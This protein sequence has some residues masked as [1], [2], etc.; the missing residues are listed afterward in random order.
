MSEENGWIEVK[1]MKKVRRQERRDAQNQEKQKWED[2]QR[3]VRWIVTPARALRLR[4]ALNIENLDVKLT[5]GEWIEYQRKGWV[6]TKAVKPDEADKIPQSDEYTEYSTLPVENDY[7]DV[8]LF[9]RQLKP[10][11]VVEG[12]E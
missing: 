7:N 10:R 1:N 6:Y 2:L 8:V 5:C 11:P 4:Q 9:S 12:F 3:N